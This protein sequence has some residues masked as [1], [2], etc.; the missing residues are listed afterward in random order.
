MPRAAL[1]LGL[2]THFYGPLAL[3]RALVPLMRANGYGRIVNVGTHMAALDD[4]QRGWPAYRISKLALNAF[5]RMLADELRNS[6]ILVNAATPGWVRTRMGGEQA[7][8]DPAQGA[9]TL[10][11]LATLPDDGPTGG[12]FENRQPRA[13]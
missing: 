9:D 2:E 1:E 6:N 12:F 5:T 10:L 8:L 4:M 11:W 13:W 7:P 3:C